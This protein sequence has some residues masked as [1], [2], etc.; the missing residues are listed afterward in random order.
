[1]STEFDTGLPSARQVQMMIRDR[2]SVEIKLM[3]GDTLTGQVQW[4]DHNAVCLNGSGQNTI[5]MRG[6][7]AYI[8]TAG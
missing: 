4:Q 7:I 6:A 2:Q 3:T 8:K 1:M 5:L